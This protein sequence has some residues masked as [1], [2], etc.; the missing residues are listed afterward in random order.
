MV[1]DLFVLELVDL[2]VLELVDLGRPLLHLDELDEVNSDVL[3][4][5]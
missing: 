2:F 4:P 5:D 1:V 3:S